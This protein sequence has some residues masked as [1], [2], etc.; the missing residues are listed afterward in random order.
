MTDSPEHELDLRS[1]RFLEWDRLLKYLCDQAR[2]AWAK[3]LILQNELD[4]T[5]DLDLANALLDETKEALSV[6]ESNS[7]LMQDVIPDMRT[8][9]PVL[10]SGG[11]LQPLELYQVLKLLSLAKNTKQSISLLS[12][13][14]FPQLNR[15]APNL[16]AL[17]DLQSR[18]AQ[19]ID[20]GGNISDDASPRLSQIRSSIRKLHS[21]IK[22]ELQKLIH[23][24][25]VAKVLQ[26][27]IYTIR[28][29]RY[30][31]PVNA[32]ERNS[33]TVNGIVHD[34]S[35]SGLTVYIEPVSVIEPTNQIRLNESEEERE[36]TRI[37]NELC[38][39]CRQNMEKLDTNYG[40][41]TKIDIVMARARLA[42]KSGGKRPELKAVQNKSTNIELLNSRHPLLVLH[43]RSLVIANDLVMKDGDRTL[44]ITGPNTGGKTV[45]L[46]Q[47]GLSCL[48][49]KCG[50][51]PCL[52]SHSVVPLFE[53]VW[54]DIGDE[55][56][57]E[58]SL[59]TFSSH[60]KNIV[61]IVNHAKR[62]TLV[63]LDEIGVG[64]DPQE[65]AALAQAILERLNDSQATTV[66]TTHYGELKALGYTKN[67]FVNGSLAFD[68]AGIVP[69][70]KLQIGIP[71]SSKGTIIAK[72]LGLA[73]DVVNRADEI[74]LAAKD[75]ASD[76][77]SELENKL[78]EA[79]EHEQWLKANKLKLVE[80]QNR[81]KEERDELNKERSSMLQQVTSDFLYEVK[82][83]QDKVKELIKD[84]QKQPSLAKAQ[85]VKDEIARL[86][87]ERNW[88]EP[89]E[90]K[91]QNQNQDES[92]SVPVVF[93]PGQYV[94][95]K[96][97]AQF[98]TIESVEH[99]HAFVTVGRART[100]VNLEDLS[101][102]VIPSKRQIKKSNARLLDPKKS[103]KERKMSEPKHDQDEVA[104]FVRTSL[105]TLDLRGLRADDAQIELE[106]F[107]DKASLQ[108]ISP[109]MV[110]HG[111][112][113][114][115]LKSL[116]RSH[117]SS[118]SAIG[119]QRPGD[120]HEGGDGVTIASIV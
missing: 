25:K 15:H 44:I 77:M 111:H 62:A 11:S 58:Q 96:S 102:A 10:A 50:L 106:A 98:G 110:I 47:V 28:S 119:A 27:P 40:A 95:L 61:G 45:L 90:N 59:S 29:G 92:K 107:I 112:G 55:Q 8:I 31:L 56:S 87:S 2:S 79:I 6:I 86:K 100:R 116:V 69:T 4:H 49:V 88:V 109:I 38:D 54:A 60:M 53:H 75:E 17:E 3:E 43:E 64:T 114:G 18:I 80:K 76:L 52:D 94:E 118:S 104:G 1:A 93:A 41:L 78:K 37:L 36:I 14:S 120:S 24:S 103:R 46:K 71:G 63:L 82:S 26:E 91:K 30:V 113:T 13:E 7:S 65:G 85:K 66:S 81:L 33:G 73:S 32:N 21:R 99:D 9:L 115:A 16:H 42:I 97:I 22:D 74:L 23:S 39:L 89:K 35:Q 101:L 57:L 67:G 108:N 5:D 19:C 68:D 83:A 48:M 105:N 20:E 51:L 34:S 70:Y 72:R 84:L 117:L 12:Q